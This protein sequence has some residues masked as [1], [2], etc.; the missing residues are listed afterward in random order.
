MK[1][2]NPLALAA[3]ALAMSA[4]TLLHAK[5]LSPADALARALP[6]A[7]RAER[8]DATAD[9]KLAYTS[10]VPGMDSVAGCYFYK[11]D[12]GFIVA[13][14]DD[15]AIPLLAYGEDTTFNPDSIS[16]ELEYWLRE[17]GR[18][19]HAVEDIPH[20]DQGITDPKGA[21]EPLCKTKWN[22]F[23]PYYDMCSKAYGRPVVTGCVA[24][25]LAQVLKYHN[26]PEQ[27][28]GEITYRSDGKEFSFDY[29]AT[30]FQWDKMLDSYW[31]KAPEEDKEAVATLMYACGVAV[32]MHYHP[33][34]SGADP[35][36]MCGSLPVHMKYDRSI[37]N[38][39]RMY[40]T[41]QEWVDLIYD[42]LA[43]KQPVQYSGYVSS[44]GGHS[45][46]CDGYDKGGY[47]HI[48]WGWGG[49]SDGY[50][51]LTSLSPDHRGIGPAEARGGFNFNQDAIINIFPA[52]DTPSLPY[53][54]VMNAGSFGVAQRWAWTGR[55]INIRGAYWNT[56]PER[57]EG[58]FGVAAVNEKGD[59]TL[60]PGYEIKDY[61]AN[62]GRGGYSVHIPKDIEPGTYTISP[63][64]E[65][66]GSWLPIKTAVNACSDEKMTVEQVGDR[67]KAV[68]TREAEEGSVTAIDLKAPETI[69]PKHYVHVTAT[70]Q[71]TM[72]TEWM[73]AIAAGLYTL[74]NR[75]IAYGMRMEI[76]IVANSEQ[77]LTYS[78][79][80][81]YVDL[82]D[83]LIQGPA[84]IQLIDFYSKKPISSPVDVMIEGEPQS[85]AVTAV[86]APVE[87]DVEVYTLQGVCLG[88]HDAASL[89]STLRKGIYILRRPDGQA[90]K[91]RF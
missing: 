1:N 22:Q 19:M 43:K 74:D 75:L 34:G 8:P 67:R 55:E 4:P 39:Q 2:I 27:G 23:G 16:P 33:G 30:T 12:K 5:S 73:G 28:V 26:W 88:K 71:N 90:R 18:E 70:L 81:R 58:R 45:F 29:G 57:I 38:A 32:G 11:S 3:L 72:D 77:P 13:S 56:A 83:S 80:F 37:F 20:V 25:A 41:L 61:W 48:N 82:P 78:S 49:A 44:G 59:T 89:P 91:V 60:M 66:N 15:R 84:M 47:F 86:E 35:A 68:F 40:Y 62:E 6:A 79:E 76:D 63:I 87:G 53:Y 36:V 46:V 17:Y 21:I 51:L 9:W 54:G 10:T 7:T 14:A 24:T 85:S 69:D 52:G 64:F 65:Y 50:Y 42:Q 31:R